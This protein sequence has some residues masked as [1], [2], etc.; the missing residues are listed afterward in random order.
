MVEAIRTCPCLVYLDLEGNTLG[1]QAAEA[2]AKALKERGASLKRALWKDM[3]TGR[4]KTE[5]PK[6]LEYLGTALCTAGARLTELDLSDN[7][8]GPIGIEG[9]A[10][11]LTSSACYTLQ[12]LRLN[13]NGLGISGGKILAQALLKCHEN[14]SKEGIAIVIMITWELQTI[15]FTLFSKYVSFF[16]IGN[17]LALKV[18][19]VGRNRLENEGAKALASVFETLQTLEEVAMPQ[20]GIY[21]EG[22][23]T[24]AHGLSTNPNLRILNLND[25]IIGLKGARSLAK[26]LPNFRNLEELNL[27]DCLLKTKGALPL[28][29]ALAIAG[30]HM[31]LR[32]LDL[33]HN[34]IRA[35]GGKTICQAMHDKTLLNSL[36]LNGNC[37]GITGCDLVE[38][39]LTRLGRI[40][41][42]KPLDEDCS[43]EEESEEENDNDD[44]K[45]SEEYESDNED[46]ESVRQNSKTQVVLGTVTVAE[47]LKSPIGEKLLLLQGDSVQAFIDYAQVCIIPLHKM[48]VP[49]HL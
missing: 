49:M 16:V 26:V 24:I 36:E 9:L 6:A 2:I 47:F 4:L 17:P 22:I 32:S 21:H 48:Y 25:N 39:I 5:I 41:A 13:N 1:T 14:S 19:I 30:N 20:N 7:A 34:D 29:E 42:L 40:D 12:E 23:T 11:L 37:F 8:F 38:E 18:L 10:N 44:D 33:G 15:A 31:F 43:E 3:F 45:E 35:N 28:A 27:G 46:V